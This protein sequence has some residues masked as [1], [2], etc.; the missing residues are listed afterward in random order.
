MFIMGMCIRMKI[1][2]IYILS[3]NALSMVNIVKPVRPEKNMCVGGEG[4]KI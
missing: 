4:L 2:H 1:M 3:D